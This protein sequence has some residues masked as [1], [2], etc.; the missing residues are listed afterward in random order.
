MIDPNACY[1]YTDPEMVSP[2][3]TPCH[4]ET[5]YGRIL[6]SLASVVGYTPYRI[7]THMSVMYLV[8]SDHFERF[9]LGGFMTPAGPRRSQPFEMVC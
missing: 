5:I 8:S 2:E 6:K 4:S 7:G 3:H 9:Q 1:L